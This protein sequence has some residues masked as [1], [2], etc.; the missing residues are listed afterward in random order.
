MKSTYKS[1]D[2]VTE[3]EK[4]EQK[5][6]LKFMNQTLIEDLLNDLD[7]DY[8]IDAKKIIEVINTGMFYFDIDS[9]FNNKQP[10]PG[11]ISSPFM[12]I[13][14]AC[15]NILHKQ[16]VKLKQPKEGSKNFYYLLLLKIVFAYINLIVKQGK[17]IVTTLEHLK[18]FF[19]YNTPNQQGIQD[20]NEKNSNSSFNYEMCDKNKTYTKESGE[21]VQMGYVNEY[22]MIELLRKFGY[23]ATDNFECTKLIQKDLFDIQPVTGN[24]FVMLAHMSR[25]KW[26]NQK[27]G[28]YIDSELE[29]YTAAAKLT[30]DFA[31]SIKSNRFEKCSSETSTSNS[32]SSGGSLQI[33]GGFKKR[34]MNKRIKKLL[35]LSNAEFFNSRIS[36]ITKLLGKRNKR[37][38]TKNNRKY[39]RNR[40]LKTK[41]KSQSKH[42]RK[43][44]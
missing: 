14:W 18:Y 42:F 35:G 29:K 33:G 23:G 31:E 8:F 39:L 12:A 28:N 20:Y 1:V 2:E 40:R 36:G 41:R 30:L 21:V 6:I 9:P 32:N 38:R 17:G 34:Y 26:E 4:E 24:K 16:F 22:K 5:S 44:F 13:F 43:Y 27:N 25:G 15:Q 19:L 11:Y 10:E 7:V 37:I 3:K